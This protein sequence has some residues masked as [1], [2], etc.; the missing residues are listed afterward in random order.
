MDVLV[1]TRRRGIMICHGDTFVFDRIS[2]SVSCRRPTLT[3]LALA[4]DL[5]E[6]ARLESDLL[7]DLLA[8][9]FSRLAFLK[10]RILCASEGP[11]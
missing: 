11:T 3:E 5:T 9:F 6:A 2:S 4:V 10:S 8:F 1:M 7:I